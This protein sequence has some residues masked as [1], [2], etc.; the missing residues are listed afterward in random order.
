M[1]INVY[2]SVLYL[3]AFIVGLPSNLLALKVLLFH[4]KL[5]PSTILLINLTV[6]DCLLLPF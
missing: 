2:L 6:A 4:T 1:T 5:L 3:L